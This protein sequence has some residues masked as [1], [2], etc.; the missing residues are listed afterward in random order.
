M[1]AIRQTCLSIEAARDTFYNMP[2]K[3]VWPRLAPSPGN[4]DAVLARDKT[5]LTIVD[6]PLMLLTDTH[7][8]KILDDE[9]LTWS[10]VL[11]M[12]L[13]CFQIGHAQGR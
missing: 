3:A 1:F 11:F 9:N 6:D 10:A 12:S 5:S 13:T 7:I 2:A 4:T 8:T